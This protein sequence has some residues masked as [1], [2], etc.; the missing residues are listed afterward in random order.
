MGGE[1]IEMFNLSAAMGPQFAGIV[2]EMT[3]R[4]KKLGPSPFK[5]KD[6]KEVLEQELTVLS[7]QIGKKT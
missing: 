2:R 5:V 4:I 6:A 3:D 7:S 1:R